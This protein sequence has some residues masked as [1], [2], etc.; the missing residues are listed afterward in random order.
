MK[1]PEDREPLELHCPNCDHELSQPI[2]DI[3][4]DPCVRDALRDGRTP[5]DIAVLACP[6]CNRFGYYNQ[7]TSFWCRFCRLGFEVISEDEEFPA[8][9]QFVRLDGHL[10]LDDTVTETT[11]D[12]DNET[13]KAE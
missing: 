9:R 12:Y 4:K 2:N 13:R 6:K 7:G 11:V 1:T 10:T 5:G 8:H 3:W